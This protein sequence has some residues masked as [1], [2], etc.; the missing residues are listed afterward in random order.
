MRCQREKTRKGVIVREVRLCEVGRRERGRTEKREDEK[1]LDKE[2]FFKK[3]TE[4]DVWLRSS[5]V[6]PA[7]AQSNNNLPSG[8]GPGYV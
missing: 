2:A 7:K 4:A 1:G 3:E 6:F 5:Q 8:Q